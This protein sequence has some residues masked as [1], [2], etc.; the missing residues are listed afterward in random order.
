MVADVGEHGGDLLIILS[1]AMWSA[2]T[3]LLRW[4][5]PGLTTLS[6]LFTIAVIGVQDGREVTRGF[7]APA[8]WP[9]RA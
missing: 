4:R 7:V 5:P 8:G 1:M 9:Y 2:Y 3:I 6:F